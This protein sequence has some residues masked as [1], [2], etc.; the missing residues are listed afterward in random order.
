MTK[1][2]QSAIA[3]FEEYTALVNMFDVFGRCYKEPNTTQHHQNIKAY[4][5]MHSHQHQVSDSGNLQQGPGPVIP[6]L[7]TQP[8]IDYF[9]NQSVKAQLNIPKELL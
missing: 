3:T 1:D 9:N 4:K 2:C 6:C 7:W 8:V 5:N